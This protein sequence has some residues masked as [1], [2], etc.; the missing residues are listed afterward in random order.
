MYK[1]IVRFRDLS[2]GHLYEAGDPFPFDGRVIPAKR[3]DALLSDQN[4]SRR[5]LIAKVEEK[6]VEEPKAAKKPARGRKK[7]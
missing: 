1:A 2:D 6:P 7:A 3:L 4:A 5:A